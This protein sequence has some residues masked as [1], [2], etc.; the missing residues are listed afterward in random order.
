MTKRTQ[1]WQKRARLPLAV[2]IAAGMSAPA[3][4][5]TFNYGE[6]EGAF[7]TSLTAAAGWRVESQ[8]KDLIGQG[9]L[10]IPAGSTTG[11][12]TTNYD[13]GNQNFESGDTYSERV[14]GTS[15]LYLNYAP[16]GEYLSSVG[17]F[18]RGRYWYDFKTK[19]D[20][21]EYPLSEGGKDD[22]SGG[23]FLDA[24]VWTD[25]NVGEVPVTVR[26]GNQ[27]INWGE[28][29]FIQGGI[30]ATNPINVSA[31]RA[32]G[33][34]I[35]DA[36]LPV[37][38]LYTSIGLTQNITVEAYAQFDWDETRLED[39]GTFFS[40]NDFTAN[41]CGPI[42][43][44]GAVSQKN[45]P[46]SGPQVINRIANN[47]PDGDDQ[48]GVALRWYSP[49]LGNTEF[50]LYHVRYDSRLPYISGKLRTQQEIQAGS[51]LPDYYADYPEDIK[52]FGISMN[53]N[54]P[55]GWSIGAEYSFRENM[56]LQWNAFDLLNGGITPAVQGQ[57]AQQAQTFAAN[58]QN[59]L[60]AE[61]QQAA[62]DAAKVSKLYE[63]RLQEAG[64][65]APLGETI[66]GHDRHKVSQAQATF[67]KFFD[68]VL[69]ASRLSF[70]GEVGM[71]YVHDLP[72]KSEA[73]Y[74][75]SGIYGVSDYEEGAFACDSPTID[76][77]GSPENSFYNINPSN[78][79]NDGFV[80]DFSWGYRM[81]GTLTYNNAFMGAT[82]KPSL[83]WSHDVN[84]YAPAPGGAFNEGN[85]AVGL[86]LAAE[87][88]N[89]YEAAINYTN[90]FGGDYNTREDRDNITASVTYSF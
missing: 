81:R 22:A 1:Q 48:F 80:S 21:F 78:C 28:S 4:A 20:D 16:R 52:L 69:G 60:A 75:R 34:E 83:S 65:Q 37:E 18:V 86:G 46:D 68:R 12:S 2:A 63:Q 70:V 19:D 58:G 90:Y 27:V 11:A 38:A 59:A 64:G 56:P 66:R 61:Y 45:F 36:L 7:D 8:N 49:E 23:E 15:E 87:Y 50:G 88:R 35:R 32:P 77:T 44:S 26:Y 57:L 13:D 72:S 33:A 31:I 24:Y 41:D 25:W 17:T 89:N 14:S 84:G 53:T 47:E 30:N 79:T 29:T 3:G 76:V 54:V 62:Q 6:V 39:C 43:P 85:K 71:T 9:N 82:L 5:F 10:G 67:I 40:T 51:I 55:G 42:Y 73:R 74:G